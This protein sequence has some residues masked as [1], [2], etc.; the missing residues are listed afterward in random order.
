MKKTEERNEE[1]A[2]QH[3]T[4]MIQLASAWREYPLGIVEKGWR[5]KK[6]HKTFEILF[7]NLPDQICE[8]L[9]TVQQ[10]DSSR[11]LS[12]SSWSACR[13][14]KVGMIENTKNSKKNN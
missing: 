6:W 2:K 12:A 9:N 4:L 14:D 1:K 11:H 13:R 5:R 7:F 10:L 3:A 8:R